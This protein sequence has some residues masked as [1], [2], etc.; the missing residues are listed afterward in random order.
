MAMLFEP[1]DPNTPIA[2]FNGGLF[3]ERDLPILAQ[4]T[5]PAVRR[6]IL[7]AR[8]VSTSGF[9]VAMNG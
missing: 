1:L 4:K 6:S 2:G 3:V 9:I 8:M 5:V 7:F